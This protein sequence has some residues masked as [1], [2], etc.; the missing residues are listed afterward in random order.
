MKTRL[1]LL[2]LVVAAFLGLG[3][4]V[5]IQWY[6]QQP[7]VGA[8]QDTDISAVERQN[9]HQYQSFTMS[10]LKNYIGSL[11][12]GNIT[13]N[14][15]ITTNVTVEQPGGYTNLNL[16]PNAVM[17]TDA[18]DAESSIVNAVGVLT[19]GGTGSG[20]IGFNN[21]IQLAEADAGVLIVTN[22]PFL[23]LLNST[24]LSGANVDLAP[25]SGISLATNGH[26]VVISAPSAPFTNVVIT[27]G[28]GT[29]VTTNSSHNYSVNVSPSS[30]TVNG[31]A[32]HITTT[33]ASIALG[34]AATLDIGSDVATQS[35]N[36][37]FSGNNVFSKTNFSSS[38]FT[39]ST[40]QNQITPDFTVAEQL[41]TT[42]AA[43]TFLA[44]VGVDVGKV[45]AQWTLV[46][47]TNTTAAAV[48]IT[49]PANCHT[50]GTAFVTN[51]TDVW[52][53][54]YAQKFTNAFYVPIF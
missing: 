20:D 12:G 38:N 21:I 19:N 24:N 9:P 28:T 40:N 1:P 2:A 3:A 4:A 46:H 7:N 43:F 15:L 32:N 22:P 13:V 30:V 25:G 47:V 34:G 33:S 41:I 44:P 5:T 8:I 31:T 11:S 16:T 29:T 51:L 48:A 6:S 42:N 45:E 54:C 23:D 35:G 37:A 17:K 39:T 52:F 26:Q 27:P 36:N 18:R 53:N 14:N 49:S 50:V 10:Q